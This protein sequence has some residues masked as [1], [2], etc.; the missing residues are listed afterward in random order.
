MSPPNGKPNGSAAKDEPMQAIGAVI[1]GTHSQFTADQIK[2]YV[3]RLRG[4][5]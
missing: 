2:S 5:I 3:S 4:A 1:A